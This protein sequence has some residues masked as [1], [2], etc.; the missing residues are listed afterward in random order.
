MKRGRA[1]AADVVSC[2]LLALVIAARPGV[3][4]IQI[5]REAERRLAAGEVLVDIQPDDTGVADGHISAVI[6]IGASP[7]T[8]F[9]V[10]TD[11]ARTLK[12]MEDLKVCKVLETGPGGSYDIREHRSRWLALLPEMMSVFRS[13]YVQDKE[14]RFSLVR[15][16]LKYLKGTWELE[17]LNGGRATRLTYEARVGVSLPV[18]A[19]IVRH[20]LEADVPRLLNALREEVMSGR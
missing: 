2:I 20:S 19:F 18:P 6:E 9:A 13:D 14:I 7:A 15:G 4:L 16:D 17:P 12:F 3:A 8:V 11:C 5:D 1:R 10:M